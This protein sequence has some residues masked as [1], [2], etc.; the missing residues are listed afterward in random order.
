MTQPSRYPQTM[1]IESRTPAPGTSRREGGFSLIELLVA[2]TMGIIVLSAVGSLV[3]SAMRSQPEISRRA[4][5][6]TTARWVLERLTRE[7]RNGIAVDPK[8]ATSSEVSFRTYVRRSTC[9]GGVLASNLP[10]RECQV[11]YRCTTTKC[12]RLEA[13]PGVY[14]GTETTIFE[15]IDSSNVFSYS[16]NPQEAT[17]IKITLRLP[18]PSGPAALTV[19]DGASLRNATLAF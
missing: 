10:A 12:S 9:G 7:I 1:P 17:F 15:G 5:N 2:S 14:T 3:I 13:A 16:P 19:S 8:R 18:N 4:Q 11:T 6:I